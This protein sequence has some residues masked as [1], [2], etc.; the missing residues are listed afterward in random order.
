[1]TKPNFIIIGERRCGSTSLTKWMEAH[2]ELYMHPKVDLNYFI[3]DYV[4]VL[5][6][7]WDMGEIDY[8]AWD[9]NHSPEDYASLFAEG[10]G[11][12]AI[13]EKS[14]DVLFWK[15]AHERLKRF[16]PDARVIITLRNPI[17]RAWSMYWNELGKKRE[18]L[19]FEEA[20]ALE[21]ERCTRSAY[22]RDHMS[23]VRRGFYDETI[24][25]L[26]KWFSPE[27]VLVV[28][29]EESEMDPKSELRKI[30]RFL[31]INPELGL[32]RA[33]TL[34]NNN[35]TSVPHPFWTQNKILAAM[36]GAFIKSIRLAATVLIRDGYKKRRL[37]PKIEGMFRKVKTDFTM[38]EPTKQ[39]L[40]DIYRPHIENLEKML[41]KDLSFWK[42]KPIK[43]RKK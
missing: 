39:K 40:M 42:E 28:F 32:E 23:Y 31:G 33:E 11:K 30:Y 43:N 2:P 35:W 4:R 6:K 25:E 1:M 13:G 38:A 26:Y 22:E 24:S 15:P 8:S 3:D 37:L 16:M 20:I 41:G 36:E 34:Y 12:K 27:Q 10:A 9:T 14:A 5:R 19:S 29:L 7:E 18:T 17:E 21:E